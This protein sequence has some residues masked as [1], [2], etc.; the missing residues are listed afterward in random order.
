MN[1]NDDNRIEA[2]K[3]RKFNKLKIDGNNYYVTNKTKFTSN[4]IVSNDYFIKAFDFAYDMSFG[5]KGEHRRY[6]SGGSV[7]RNNDRIFVNTLQGKLAEFATY[8]YFKNYIKL[9]DVNEPDLSV[10]GKLKWDSYDLKVNNKYINIKS[11]KFFSDLLLLEKQ[12]WDNEARYIPNK[13]QEDDISYDY[14]VL[15]RI[16]PDI[17]KILWEK[18][19]YSKKYDRQNLKRVFLT[20][21]FTYNIVGFITNDDFKNIIDCNQYIP[22]GGYLNSNMLMDADNY[23]IQSDDM[24]EIE[25]LINLL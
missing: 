23:Y 9:I 7:R 5:Q 12:D 17:G 19:N 13:D 2:F 14:F 8:I 10:W 15:V 25:E 3:N 18:N 24:I 4:V 22:K 11:T 16:K 20:K 1:F 6:R 21:E